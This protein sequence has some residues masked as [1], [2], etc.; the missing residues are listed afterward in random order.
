MKKDKKF[1]AELEKN[2]VGIKDKYKKEIISKY[3][4]II[5]EEKDKNKKI[6]A[7]LKEIGKPEDVATKELSSLG[8]KGKLSVFDKLGKRY[9]EFKAKRKEN[10]EKKEQKKENEKLNKNGIK[11]YVNNRKFKPLDKKENDKKIKEIKNQVKLNKKEIEEKEEKKNKKKEKKVEEKK[12]KEKKNK[13]SFKERFAKFKEAITKDIKFKK[14]EKDKKEEEKPAKKRKVKESPKEIITEVKEEIKEEISEAAQTVSEAPIFESKEKRRKRIIIKTL[15][16]ILTMLL[17]FV[18]MWVSVLF[19]ASVV[20]YLDGVKF[21]GLIIGFFGLDL[22]VLWI[23]VMVNRAIFKHKMSLWLNIAVCFV[24]VAFIA[25]GSVLAVRQFYKIENV[26]DVSVK[27]SM[28]T[29]LN[30]YDLPEEKDKKFTI[31]FNSNYKTQ[32]TINYDEMIKDKV[33]IEVKYYEC[34]YDFYVKKVTNGAYIS[35]GTDDRDRLSIY[36]DDLKEGL[37]FDNDELSRYTVKISINPNDA[38]RVEVL[39]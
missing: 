18:W 31:T 17:L 20:A 25:I 27:Y 26:K 12:E 15:G 28:T 1:L 36:I 24:S 39:D 9:D 30:N 37:V 33:R 23:V 34:Y 32:Y 7:I 35:L 13:V 19:V 21:I 3:E 22:L 10:K 4:N 16:I 8:N 14:K 38:N 5:K 29:K 11:V 2:L 6:T